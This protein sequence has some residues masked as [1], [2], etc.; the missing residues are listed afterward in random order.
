MSTDFLIYDPNGNLV[1][2]L[3]GYAKSRKFTVG[4]NKPGSATFDINGVQLKRIADALNTTPNGILSPGINELRIKRTA[5]PVVWYPFGGRIDKV[6]TK[7]SG[8][9]ITHSITVNGFLSMLKSNFLETQRLFTAE[10]AGTIL[11]TVID[12]MQTASSNFWTTPLPDASN[13]DLGITEGT[14][15][16]IGDKDRTYE[17]GKSLYDILVQMT[18]L[19]TTTTD[20]EFE[21]DKTFNVYERQGSDK[22]GIVLEFKKNI[23]DFNI[24]TDGGNIANR[25][26]TYGA[27]TGAD[28]TQTIVED[29][30]SEINYSVRQ[31]IQQFQSVEE[32]D[33]LDDHGLGYLQ[34]AKDPNVIPD[35]TVDLN[36]DLSLED[37]W[38]GDRPRVKIDDP[39]LLNPIDGLYRIEEMTI[40]I[41]DNEEQSA[42]IKLA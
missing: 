2:D 5:G 10:D 38:I 1:A 39:A 18:E 4:R 9:D 24:P 35:I 13:T 40:S 11:W 25:I 33:T 21:A 41:D 23:I 16:T 29:E 34:A 30:S 31:H 17:A 12:E 27:G 42:G 26:I 37:I 20:I 22:P 32:T 7:G 6:E 36:H 3:S 15:E 19:T 28:R 8:P 14:I